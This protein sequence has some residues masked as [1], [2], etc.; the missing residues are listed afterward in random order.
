MK[1]F[2][3]NNNYYCIASNDYEYSL[4]IDHIKKIIHAVANSFVYVYSLRLIT[5]LFRYADDLRKHY[6][7][8]YFFEYD[9]FK[10]YL[11]QK[12]MIDEEALSF[13]YV[14][15]AHTILKL[16]PTLNSYNILNLFEYD[17]NYISLLNEVLEKLF[18]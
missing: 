15:E 2:T 6:N 16:N 8:Y 9:N 12:E 18:L 14:D 7:A 10:D 4:F 11:Y 3:F 17:D 13:L 1:I 5:Q